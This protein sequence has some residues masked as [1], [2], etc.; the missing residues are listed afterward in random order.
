MSVIIKDIDKP[1]N[2]K[3]CYFNESNCYCN[4]TKGCIDRDDYQC[5]TPCPID[6]LPQDD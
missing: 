3:D 4:I 5:D 2:C 1:D 6:Q